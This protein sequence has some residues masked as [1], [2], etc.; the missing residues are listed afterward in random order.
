MVTTIVEWPAARHRVAT[1]QNNC[2]RRIV[3]PF[4]LKGVGRG[5]NCYFGPKS[6]VQVQEIMNHNAGKTLDVVHITTSHK[7]AFVNWWM[8]YQLM[9]ACMAT[10]WTALASARF[11]WNSTRNIKHKTLI[12]TQCV[13]CVT[14]LSAFA[15][16]Y[17]IRF[18]EITFPTFKLC[19]IVARIFNKLFLKGI[20][21]NNKL[22]IRQD[23]SLSP[24]PR[25]PN[26]Y[27]PT[28]LTLVWVI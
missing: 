21:L 7:H 15:S 27:S 11:Y 17:N 25:F 16:T 24:G 28:H 2:I 6:E 9:N 3:T 13:R 19:K 8:E 18:F 12:G 10:T 1:L 23:G 14:P 4:I 26:P 5:A 22:C 20:K